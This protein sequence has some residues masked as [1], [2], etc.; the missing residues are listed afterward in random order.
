MSNKQVVAAIA[1]FALFVLVVPTAAQADT[2]TVKTTLKLQH[3]QPGESSSFISGKLSSPKA[4]CTK[5]RKL[6]ALA[7]L[8][9]DSGQGTSLSDGTFQIGLGG[10]EDVMQSNGYEASVRKKT[11]GKGNK[12][13]VCK[14]DEADVKYKS[15]F[16]GTSIA[17]AD[18]AFS[19]SMVSDDRACLG[20][21]TIDVTKEADGGGLMVQADEDGNWTLPWSN[22]SPGIY[23][24][25][26]GG[27]FGNAQRPKQDGDLDVISCDTS[28]TQM[29]VE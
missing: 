23:R 16:S 15:F 18:G 27:T 21:R 3:L 22:P 29:E 26:V 7:R 28:F 2:Q 8:N 12:K 24:A 9:A 17:Y 13:T 4:A 1:A 5:G 19:G 11:I 25:T 10:F 14:A 20:F 6:E